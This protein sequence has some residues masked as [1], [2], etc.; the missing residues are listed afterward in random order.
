MIFRKLLG[1]LVLCAAASAAFGQVAP[2]AKVGGIPLEVGA[3]FSDFASDWSGRLLGYTIWADWTFY[4]APGALSGIGIE[5][6][7]RQLIIQQNTLDPK[8]MQATGEGGVIYK[9]RRIPVFHPYGKLLAGYGGMNFST[10]DPNYSHDTR[11]VVAEG[12]GADFAF[13]DHF[14]VRADFENQG[15][16][17][18]FRHHSLTP[19]GFTVGI[20]WDFKSHPR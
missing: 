10:P 5:V 11:T 15:W 3:G 8:L 19:H 6:L 7:G 16:A 14:L 17:N 13:H 4:N 9:W 18:F 1:V 20:G 12:F 2:G